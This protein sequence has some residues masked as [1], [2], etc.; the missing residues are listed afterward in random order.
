MAKQEIS[1]IILQSFLNPIFGFIIFSAITF[2]A[3]HSYGA[4]LSSLNWSWYL[5]MVYSVDLPALKQLMLLLLGIY[6]ILVN[7]FSWKWYWYNLVGLIV[8]CILFLNIQSYDWFDKHWE[9]I[10]LRYLFIDITIIPVLLIVFFLS[11]FLNKL[12]LKKSIN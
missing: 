5:Q 8:S 4:S 10:D 3:Q 11:L 9:L 1:R 2:L 7:F 12:V 6:C